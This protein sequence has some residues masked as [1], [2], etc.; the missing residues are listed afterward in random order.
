MNRVALDIETIPGVCATSDTGGW[1]T[2][3][4]VFLLMNTH[5]FK[6]LLNDIQME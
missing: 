2:F 4:D 1:P 3:L 5:G 6:L